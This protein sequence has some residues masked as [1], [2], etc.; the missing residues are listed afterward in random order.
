[1]F[2][3]GKDVLTEESKPKLDHVAEI[4]NAHPTYKIK[5]SGYTD[6]SG[7]EASNLVLSKKRATAVKNYLITDDVAANR[8]IADGFGVANPVA[9]NST[10]EGRAKN[11]RVEFEIVFN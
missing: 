5:V 1:N 6:S 4:L 2:L 11:R 3:S 10:R 9:D 8:I 7:N